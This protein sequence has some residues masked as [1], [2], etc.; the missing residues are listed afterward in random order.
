LPHT[1]SLKKQFLIISLSFIKPE[2]WL[3][4]TANTENTDRF[5]VQRQSVQRM[6]SGKGEANNLCYAQSPKFVQNSGI[7]IGQQ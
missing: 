2:P 6:A 1:P 7:K 5:E 3:P 4:I